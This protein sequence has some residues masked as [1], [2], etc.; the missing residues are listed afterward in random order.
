MPLARRLGLWTLVLYG[1]GDVLGAGIYALVGKVAAAAGR[2]AWISFLISAALAAITGL[3][4]AELASRVPKSAGA[5]AYAGQAFPRRWVPFLVGW[6]VLASG[7]TS[8]AAVSL[9]L[10]GYLQSFLSIPPLW[11]ALVFL[12]LA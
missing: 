2:G 9:A 12:L 8:A 5:A 11:G 10:H 4:Y 3:T 1:I 6:L 7:V